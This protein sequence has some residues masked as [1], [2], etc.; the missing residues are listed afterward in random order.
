[1]EVGLNL[2]IIIGEIHARTCVVMFL[3]IIEYGS[4]AL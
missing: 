4:L 3:G 2:G 1:M